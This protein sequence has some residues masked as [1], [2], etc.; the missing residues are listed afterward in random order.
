MA[1]SGCHIKC[2]FH[3]RLKISN[4][5]KLKICNCL[6]IFFSVPF[7]IIYE[8]NYLM[9]SSCTCTMNRRDCKHSK[10]I[11]IHYFSLIFKMLSLPLL[12]RLIILWQFLTFV[13][14]C[15]RLHEVNPT[16]ICL[17]KISSRSTRNILNI[18]EHIS[19]LFLVFLS[20]TLKK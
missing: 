2:F 20:V 13:A 19:L 4:M 14:L 8:K 7:F 6:N 18:S 10:N 15:V 17:F 16:S 5:T 11:K 9:H 12:K 1:A 3:S